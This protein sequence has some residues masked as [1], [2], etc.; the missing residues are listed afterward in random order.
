MDS[1]T[2]SIVLIGTGKD[3]HAILSVLLKEPGIVIIGV[4]DSDPG[5]PG[6]ELARQN[7]IPVSADFRAF[8]DKKP[9]IVISAITDASLA[10]EIEKYKAPN[11][12]VIGGMCARIMGGMFRKQFDAEEKAKLL[13]DETKELYNIGV[14]LTSADSL[15]KILDTLLREALRTLKAPAGSV[16]LY[17]ADTGCLHL[18]PRW[19]FQWTS[20]RFPSGKNGKTA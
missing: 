11:T 4:S 10:D 19:D 9:D 3:M 5:A 18:R 7:G 1:L 13:I 20:R 14:A 8:L 6:I 12:E 2:G 15:E 17:D 16:A